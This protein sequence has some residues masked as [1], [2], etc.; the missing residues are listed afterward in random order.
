MEAILMLAI[1]IWLISTLVGVLILYSVVK[2]AINHSV[3][4]NIL[5]ETR[6][7]NDQ[8]TREIKALTQQLEDIKR[9][10]HDRNNHV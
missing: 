7:H 3:L 6:H 5:Q 9:L 2:A 10:L 1:L 4:G 8:K